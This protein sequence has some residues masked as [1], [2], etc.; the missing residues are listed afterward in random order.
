M[1][2]FKDE[3]DCRTVA[4]EQGRVEHAE[5]S[6]YNGGKMEQDWV[7]EEKAERREMKPQHYLPVAFGR[8][9][10]VGAKRPP[11]EGKTHEE[12]DLT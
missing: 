6:A 7:I 3:K 12:E 2:I 4:Y 10:K 11:G 9:D 8:V 1:E 5:M